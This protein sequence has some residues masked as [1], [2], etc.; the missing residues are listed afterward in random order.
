[1]STGFFNENHM[2]HWAS[3]RK[4]MVTERYERELELRVAETE[5]AKKWEQIAKSHKK[6]VK[7]SVQHKVREL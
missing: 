3:T 6:H 2:R 4:S 5:R 7:D 1:M